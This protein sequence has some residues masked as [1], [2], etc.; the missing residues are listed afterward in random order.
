VDRAEAGWEYDAVF[1]GLEWCSPS[2][3]ALVVAAAMEAPGSPPPRIPAVAPL[4]VATFRHSGFITLCLGVVGE[5]VGSS[6][7]FRA[8]G[9]VY[10]LIGRGRVGGWMRD[11]E[12]EEE[13][14]DAEVVEI[15]DAFRA[16]SELDG[17]LTMIVVTGVDIHQVQPLSNFYEFLVVTTKG[18]SR[19]K[20][21][22]KLA[23]NHLKGRSDNLGHFTRKEPRSKILT[24]CPLLGDKRG[25]HR[26]R[27]VGNNVQ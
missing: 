8:C 18:E 26:I 13:A 4:L 16:S 3:G 15:T 14:D 21:V 10:V 25:I 19:S 22:I 6:G 17:P 23:P 1:E 24:I 20:S 7:T 5:L 27:S 2:I 12:E 11:A 9:P